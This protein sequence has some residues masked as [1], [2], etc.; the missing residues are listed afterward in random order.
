MNRRGFGR[1]IDLFVTTRRFKSRQV[2]EVAPPRKKCNDYQ[3]R[4]DLH[5]TCSCQHIQAKYGLWS[6]DPK[7]PKSINSPP[8]EFGYIPYTA[9]I[10]KFSDLFCTNISMSV[11]RS[12]VDNFDNLVQTFLCHAYKNYYTN[13]SNATDPPGWQLLLTSDMG[14]CSCPKTQDFL[15]FR[16]SSVVHWL[17]KTLLGSPGIPVPTPEF[18]MGAWTNVWAHHGY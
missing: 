2:R 14:R 12:I 7:L 3:I 10:G 16:W 9:L 5:L 6:T 18:T 8:S 4:C 1:R 15:F 13:E 11:M 17:S